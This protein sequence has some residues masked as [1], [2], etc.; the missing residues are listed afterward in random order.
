MPN[1]KIKFKNLSFGF[2]DKKILENINLSIYPDSFNV[3]LGPS[4][5]GKSS[6]LYLIAGIETLDTPNKHTGEILIDGKDVA[7]I[8]IERR[9]CAF[10]FQTPSLFAHKTV[11][12]NLA[13]AIHKCDAGAKINAILTRMQ[14]K[15]YLNHYPHQL[16]IG[17]QQRISF[18]RAILSDKDIILLDEPFSGLDFENK[19]LL[20]NLLLD[21]KLE[22]K[23]TII[24]VTH[25]FEEAAFFGSNFFIINNNQ[26]ENHL[27]MRSIYNNPTNAYTASFFAFTNIV[28]SPC[29]SSKLMIRPE[30]IAINSNGELKAIIKE[31]K[32]F[33]TYHIL[34]A[35]VLSSDYPKIQQ[36]TLLFI[37]TEMIDLKVNQQIQ[38][39]IK[40]T[41]LLN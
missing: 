37:K 20:Y 10:V 1:S 30:D 22:C 19:F 18:A 23:K 27:D 7:N 4:G 15:E 17:Q 41:L 13:F 40:K 21:I 39:N 6:I 25:D 26:I 11:Y 35:K 14:M 36:D 33:G 12:Q 5:S 8:P 29:F 24:L 38:I 2:S 31:I 9:S 3:I 34:L 32:F 28:S 16:S